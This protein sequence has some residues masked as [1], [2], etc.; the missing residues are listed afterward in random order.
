MTGSTAA[1]AL[2]LSSFMVQEEVTVW[3]H[4]KF[5]SSILKAGDS[6]GVAK[7]KA[8]REGRANLQEEF[9]TKRAKAKESHVKAK[10]EAKEAEGLPFGTPPQKRHLLTLT[11]VLSTVPSTRITPEKYAIM[12]VGDK[13]CS[14]GVSPEL[15]ILTESGIWLVKAKFPYFRQVGLEVTKAYMGPDVGPNIYDVNL[16]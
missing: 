5:A 3:L 9:N 10:K 15:L 6:S 2:G 8:A 14:L 13:S 16:N 11:L 4:G 12:R 7:A 1:S